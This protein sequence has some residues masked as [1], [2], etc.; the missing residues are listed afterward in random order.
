MDIQLFHIFP[1]VIVSGPIEAWFSS[2]CSL[3]PRGLSD[4]P[5]VLVSIHSSAL[6]FCPYLQNPDNF[7]KGYITIYMVLAVAPQ[8]PLCCIPT[9]SGNVQLLMPF[10]Y[11]KSSIMMQ[12]KHRMPS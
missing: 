1:W 10:P 8:R 6:G 4:E 2:P 12:S 5:N 11:G 3:S 9:L 7:W